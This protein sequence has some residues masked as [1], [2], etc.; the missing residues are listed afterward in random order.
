[1][2]LAIA[3]AFL[4]AGASVTICDISEPLLSK[5]SESHSELNTIQADIT[6]DEEV[7]KVFDAAIQK[8][9]RVDVLINNAGIMDKYEPVAD[10]KRETWDKVL[11]V[12]ATAPMVA[13]GCAIREFLKRE[14]EEGKARGAIVNVASVAVVK[15]VSAG[16]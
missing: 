1:M 15:S 9:G 10:M 3:N 5:A 2:G 6:R 7:Q 13:S 16:N 11:A 8:F 12:N 14:P 4:Q